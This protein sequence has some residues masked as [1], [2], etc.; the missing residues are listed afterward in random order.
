MSKK[1]TCGFDAVGIVDSKFGAGGGLNPLVN[2]PVD[3]SECIEFEL[4][5]LCGTLV[6][7]LVLL[8]KMVEE[9]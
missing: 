8:V 6:D 5:A 1:V 9:L 7:L 4:H 2:K 3:D